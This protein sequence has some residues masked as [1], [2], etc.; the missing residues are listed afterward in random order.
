DG[1]AALGGEAFV[2]STGGGITA[3]GGVSILA[4]GTGGRGADDDTG[5]SGSTGFG[6]VGGAGTGGTANF[7]AG[8]AV[9]LGGGGLITVTGDTVVSASGT[10][11][12]GG[13]GGA[14]SGGTAAVSARNG[15]MGGI[16]LSVRA[17][18]QGG[19]AFN[20]GTGGAGNG[21][22]GFGGTAEVIARS[23]LQG[24]STI[25]FET[26]AIT[27]RGTGG[28]GGTPASVAG[29]GTA[30]GAGTGGRAQA[31]AEAGNGVLILATTTL[32]ASG[33]G[34]SGGNGSSGS[35]GGGGGAGGAAVGGTARLGVVPGLDTGPVLEGSA[36]FGATS[37]LANG[38]G[39]AG[40]AGG[41]G[42]VFG[43]DGT[44]GNAQGGG[45]SITVQ[46]GQVT[47]DAAALVQANAI[48]GDGGAGNGGN[49]AVGDSVNAPDQRG[50]QLVVGSGP[51]GQ[52]GR[53]VATSAVFSAAAQGGAGGSTGTATILGHPLAFRVNGGTVDA[54]SLAF[55]ASG[56]ASAAAPSSTI[57]LAGGN[58]TLTGTF[59]FITPGTL[60]AALSGADLLSSAATV[61]AS[62]WLEGLVP[63]GSAGTI[64]GTTSVSLSTGGDLFGN[65]SAQ[66]DGSL[67][68]GAGGRVRLDNLTAAGSISVNAGTT[69]SLGNLSA[70]STVSVTAPGNVS[71]GNV[72]SIGDTTLTSG[73]ALTA[74]SVT[75][76]QSARLRGT[77]SLTLSGSVVAGDAVRLS[78]DGLVNGQG[79]S[80]G[81]VNP[82]SLPGASYEIAVVGLGGIGLG[83]VTTARDIR[84]FTPLALTVGPLLGRDIALLSG[85]AQVVDRISAL[86]RVLMANYSMAPIGGDPLL[87]GY[88]MAALLGTAPVA[89]GGSFTVAGPISAEGLAAFTDN[90]IAF[91][92]ITATTDGT[93]GA[94]NLRAGGALS[95][96]VIRADQLIDARAGGTMNLVSANSGNILVLDGTGAITTGN[97]FGGNSL[98]VTGAGA[99]STGALGSDLGGAISLSSVG[100]MDIASVTSGGLAV[101]NAGGALNGGDITAQSD[102]LVTGADLVTLGAINSS[103]GRAQ[104]QAANALRTGAIRVA[105][106]IALTSTTGSVT[107]G[108]LLADGAI[109]AISPGNVSLGNVTSVSDVT[110]TAGVALAAGS[111]TS[112]Q[113]ARL[114]GTGSLTLSGTMVAGAAVQLSSGGVVSGQGVSAGLVNPSAASGASYDITVVG[115]GGIN[116]GVVAAAQD[117]KLFTP[118]TIT[119]GAISGREIALL[120]GD[121]QS[122]GSIAATGRVL[123]ADYSMAPIGGDPLGSYDFNAL[124][125]AVPIASGGAITVSGATTAGALRARSTRDIAVQA[126]I[127]S[128]SGPA[129]GLVELLADG[130]IAGGAIAAGGPVNAVSG[131]T[132]DLTSASSGGAL[133][134]SAGQALTSG[135]LTAVNAL[136][137][138]TGG[139][140]VT[141]DL[142]GASVSGVAGT[143]LQAGAVNATGGGLALTAAD[144]L[145]TGVITASGAVSVQSTAGAVST[146]GISA[147][148][149]LSVLAAGNL[150]AGALD[151]GGTLDAAG[152]NVALGNVR[153]VIQLNVTA[154]GTLV[155]GAVESTQGG[156]QMFSA[157]GMQ[158]GAINA[159]T[160]IQ[161]GGPSTT[162]T[163]NLTAGNAV[164]VSSDG[165]VTLGAALSRGGTVELRSNGGSLTVGAV[166]AFT[167]VALAAAND[168]AAGDVNARDMLLLAGRNARTGNLTSPDGRILVANSSLVTD[169]G[170]IGEYNF[171]AVFAA[172]LRATGGTLT[173]TGPVSGGTFTAAV[174]GDASLLGV[175]ASRSIL[176]Q[177]G[178]ALV[179]GDLRGASVDGVAGTSLQAGAVNATGGALTLTAAGNLT[180]G[181]LAATGAVQVQST[182]SGVQ[183]GGVSSGSTVTLVAAGSLQA[184]ALSAA[185]NVAV[186]GGSVALGTISGARVGLSS[187]GAIGFGDVTS[188]GGDVSLFAN[189]A[190][191][192]G[193]ITT[194]GRINLANSAGAITLGNLAAAD[195]VLINGAGAVSAGAVSA[196]VGTVELRA[197]SGSLTLGAVSAGTD[198]ALAAT[199][200]LL[201]GSAAARDMLL[202]AGGNVRTGSLI[203][204]DGR[205]LVA[206][207]TLVGLGG[208]VGEYNFD[209][210]FS[211]ALRDTGGTLTV[212]GPVSGGTFTA[213]VR[214]DAALAGVTASRSILVRSGGLLSLGG[215]LAAPLIDLSSNDLAMPAGSGLNAGLTGT[216]RLVSTNGD[217]MRI[218]DGLDTSIL[219]AGSFTM[220][221]AEWSRINS[222]SLSLFG[223][224]G[225]EPVDIL[226]GRLDMTG[227]DAGSTID[228]PNGRVL[229]RTGEAPVAP[230]SGT[231]RVT[232]AIRGTGFRASNALVFQTG[233]FQLSSDTGSI[234]LL[235]RGGTPLGGV[236]IEARDIHF[237]AAPLL[238]RLAADPF[239][240]GAE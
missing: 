155:T 110:L 18:G 210:V 24:S 86:G 129:N 141:G 102:L 62:D 41:A 229:F 9:D 126:V 105:D 51:A 64:R 118:L 85:G 100:T 185:G 134:L 5:V 94:V 45:A 72:T 145:L 90:S 130:T 195:T 136:T 231:I 189:G 137:L 222:G 95:S 165:D 91:Q 39:G 14:G 49:A 4:E 175:T 133:T 209:P 35:I 187:N 104:I 204:R 177:S 191:A 186:N 211:G 92:N 167:D 213:A 201:L 202:L 12:A 107:A 46:G 224:D 190:V 70:G 54:T 148:A 173:M 206:S 96:G 56:T 124:L 119:A 16:G 32:N 61:S 172:A 217:G 199:D 197:G 239:F 220:D 57:S 226:I 83:T 7:T 182:D 98:T 238:A 21:G 161:I 3:N 76:R 152:A 166:S 26:T 75:S 144:S 79:L 108:D 65:L 121:A 138:N 171:D 125:S 48:G 84:L 169:G 219:P 78:S 1:G 30:G 196:D 55:S 33:G 142:R 232:G 147:G 22:A 23:A 208:I 10:G 88:D 168:L 71:V 159:A 50:V 120:S 69:V 59:N 31:L 223:V 20:G 63:A 162:S 236:Q 37:V 149:N 132:M 60:T 34:G 15:A 215:V 143:S 139:A 97:L 233:L 6:G 99:V 194:T 163:G 240:A 225:G 174:R 68:L 117:I 42:A 181:T 8:D 207:N 214:G 27:A 103:A 179:A 135:N 123:L 122:I 151:A 127:T 2:K 140:L 81:R 198:I 66:T 44:G 146:Q 218:G 112:R 87:D 93:T 237:A 101:F 74:G 180:A 157:G 205:I 131:G 25:T 43:A 227:P 115:L 77:G 47:L 193:S 183:T 188:V 178:G 235:G 192:G 216:I 114:R 150:Q 158:T 67:A 184:G 36:S 19:A 58:T 176:V 203:S 29:P 17:F 153:S 128:V 89:S 111:V 11:A 200:D 160:K 28:A 13:T 170:A 38:L 80:A 234:T 156:V 40:G 73:A 230:P 221:N 212:T 228:D 109:S 82:S 113:S 53:L 116:L 106:A 52:Q 164:L 154:T